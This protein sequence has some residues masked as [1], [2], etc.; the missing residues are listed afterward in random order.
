MS[1]LLTLVKGNGLREDQKKEEAG[2]KYFDVTTYF[3]KQTITKL[4]FQEIFSKLHRYW[5]L[6][7]IQ[8][9]RTT[10]I[11]RIQAASF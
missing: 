10:V 8:K 7:I 9:W 4:L 11:S 5:G 1:W 3:V 2:K 6:R